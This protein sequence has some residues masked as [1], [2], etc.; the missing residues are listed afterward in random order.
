MFFSR[1]IYP[2]IA[3]CCVALTRIKW[4]S[5]SLHA[6]HDP[7]VASRDTQRSEARPAARAIGMK[8]FECPYICWCK[9]VVLILLLS[10]FAIRARV[11]VSRCSFTH[12]QLP[13]A[14]S[15]Y[16]L[17]V[18]AARLH[19]FVY[20]YGVRTSLNGD[21]S[22]ACGRHNRPGPSSAQ[23]PVVARRAER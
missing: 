7:C 9:C 3:P 17:R 21:V 16:S 2:K 13:A 19:H 4:L 12:W 18:H 11:H 22:G 6:A 14:A 8:L 10:C 20:G 15:S 23:E 1:R 5:R